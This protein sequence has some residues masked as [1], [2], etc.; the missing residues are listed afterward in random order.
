MARGVGASLAGWLLLLSCARLGASASTEFGPQVAATKGEVWPKPSRQVYY[1]GYLVVRPS[2]FTFKVTG[3][4]CALLQEALQRYSAVLRAHVASG[5]GA[6]GRSSWRH[7]PRVQSLGQLQVRLMAACASEPSLHMDEHYELRVN[8]PDLPGSGLLTSQSV[9]GILR[10]L[11]TFSQIL[12]RDESGKALR[13]NSTA[14]MDFPRFTHRGLLL[15]TSRHFLPTATIRTI[16]DGMEMNKMNV[17]HWHI[18]DDQSF[19]YQSDIFPLLSKKGAY[20]PKLIYT[21]SDIKN[22]TEYARLRG[23]RVLPEFDSPGHTLSW[24][25]GQPELLTSCYKDDEPDGTYGPINPILNS[26]YKFV[27]TLFKEVVT[28]F[29][30]D[31]LHLGGDEVSFDCW[32]SNPNITDFMSSNG[33]G[34]YSELEQYYMQRVVNITSG[35]GARSIVWQEVFDNGVVIPDRTVVHIWTGDQEE[36]LEKGFG[37]DCAVCLLAGA[38]DGGRTP[39]SS[40]H[41]LVPG[42]PSVGRRLEEVLRVRADQL[43]RDRGPE[44]AGDGRRGVHV[45]GGGGR[46]QRG[47]PGLA[48]GLGHGREAVVQR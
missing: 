37:R 43:Q 3:H 47:V 1:D 12:H 27:R 26:T 41:L 33:I 13:V 31:Y 29:P 5:G 48:Q 2:V 16:L 9:W 4:T 32:Q 17:F 20:H 23:I 28:L 21:Q 6:P 19:P 34:N 44:A 10:G 45:G 8:S 24:G 18:V 35:L 36:H 30:D 46:E 25:Q 15:D 11:E 42:P 14:I 7:Q 40:V 39:S 22:I 38:G